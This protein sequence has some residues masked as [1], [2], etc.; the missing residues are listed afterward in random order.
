M[1]KWKNWKAAGITDT[2]TEKK[3]QEAKIFKA[4]SYIGYQT[5]EYTASH[6]TGL[7]GLKGRIKIFH[8][9]PLVLW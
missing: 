1:V 8:G 6:R 7:K 3:T 4:I 9:H 5:T 2:L